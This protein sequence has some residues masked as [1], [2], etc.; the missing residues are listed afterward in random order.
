MLFKFKMENVVITNTYTNAGSTDTNEN[1]TL[2]I[3]NIS[4]QEEV[5][6]EEI[7]ALVN[8]IADIVK[9]LITAE[10]KK[11][12]T[13][14]FHVVK[15][16]DFPNP[17]GNNSILYYVWDRKTN[18]HYIKVGR[19]SA[20]IMS[21]GYFKESITQHKDAKRVIAEYDCNNFRL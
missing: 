21:P 6:P 19:S 20:D 12:S 7:G 2:N 4:L 3:E 13:K 8:G 17:N 16:H 14:R 10:K 11:N 18:S 5:A 9:E 1:T 15:T